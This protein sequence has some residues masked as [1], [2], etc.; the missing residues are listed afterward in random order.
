MLVLALVGSTL[1]VGALILLVM[2]LAIVAL[3]LFVGIT[4]GVALSGRGYDPGIAF[5]AAFALGVA[6]LVAGQIAFA[7]LRSPTIRTVV[8]LLFVIPAGVVAYGVAHGV[9][10]LGTTSES[11]RLIAGL[12]GA[13]GTGWAAFLR[14]T[15]GF[16][17]SASTACPPI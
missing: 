3:P 9:L 6:T 5:A 13:G 1:A 16:R 10:G 8:A 14:L 17:P 11:L 15:T 2:R 12:V 7:T 4:V